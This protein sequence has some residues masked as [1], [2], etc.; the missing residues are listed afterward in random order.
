M[1]RSELTERISDHFDKLSPQLRLAARHVLENPDAVAML[2][3]RKLAADAGV[4]PSTMVRLARV[5]GFDGFNDFREPFLHPIRYQRGGYM[6]RVRGLQ[7]REDSGTGR[8]KL[9]LELLDSDEKNLRRA[10]EETG[11]AEL[12]ASVDLLNKTSRIFVL[13]LRACHPI[14]YAFHYASRL[15]TDKSTLLGVAGFEAGDELRMMKSGDVLLAISFD[16]YTRETVRA[17]DFANDHGGKVIAMTDSLASPIAR[18][19]QHTLLMAI[20]GP[21]F[22][23]SV[24]SGVTLAHALVS[25]MAA[26]GGKKALTAIAESESQLAAF[27]AYWAGVKGA[28]A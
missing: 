19:A 10:F 4:R 21:S 24:A 15:I 12:S 20:D 18:R 2:S 3:M 1:T 6:E 28:T 5:F 14:A 9:F 25:A 22:F 7:R 17:V 23:P 26:A 27:D 16:P 13:G 11:E 8:R